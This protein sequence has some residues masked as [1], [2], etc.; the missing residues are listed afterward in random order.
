MNLEEARKRAEKLRKEIEHHNYLYYVL[1]QPEISDET[2]DGLMRELREV[3][4]R[5]PELVVP[6]SP[7]QRVG[8]EPLDEFEKV[9]HEVPML[10]LEN[11]FSEDELWSFF[12]R[13]KSVLSRD[14]LEYFCELKID[15][16]AV[17]LLYENGRL[18]RGATRGNGLVGEDVTNNIRTISSVPLK[19]VKPVEGILEVRGEVLMTKRAFSRL[20]SQREEQ[21]LPLFANPR[22]AAA[23]SLRQL[24]PKITAER[25]LNFFAYQVLYPERFGLRTQMEVIRW[26][27]ET[28]FPVQGTE[29][30]AF[31]EKEVL[32]YIA[33][34]NE[35]RHELAYAIDGVVVKVN[36]LA[37]WEVLG[38]T[39]KTPRWAVAY[40]YAPEEKRTRVKEIEISVG[41][42]GTLT[43]VAHLEP[44]RLS[45]TEVKRA[46]L[47]NADE[48]KRKDVRVGDTVW[49]RKA[50]EI[51]PEV[52]RVDITTRP[53]GLKPFEMPDS[54]PVCGS[55]V[56][57]L[58]EEVAV[59]CPNRTC[60]A[61]LRE[62][63]IHFASRSGMDI[64]GLG[65][66]IVDKLVSTGM[67]KDYADLYRLKIEDL[68]NLELVGEG[69]TRRLGE[70]TAKTIL[71]SI[72]ESK[73]RPLS[74]LLTAL[75]IR[76]VGSSVAELLA[77]TFGSI[78]E[79]MKS[80]E[81]KLAEIEGIGP[82]IAASVAAFF[83]DEQNRAMIEKLRSAGLC[84]TKEETP[85]NEE[86]PFSGLS[87]VFTGELESMTRSE[88][89]RLVKLLG[90][91][92]S[93]RVTGKTNLVVVGANPGSKL[94]EALKRNIH[95]ADEAEFVAMLKDAGAEP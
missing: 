60:P 13:T 44:V 11:A 70:K 93:S 87:V 72:E 82:R 40:K 41:R 61:Q 59:R 15:G 21:G 95:V 76:F 6:E 16:L 35:K 42:T 57:R 73:K 58:P 25:N 4:E 91:A 84:F 47:H 94:E 45:G 48:I 68:A 34:W 32:E 1:D 89:E 49:V 65:E 28:G 31:L 77:E 92:T 64:R 71:R 86:G 54:C 62:G 29:K 74:N 7:T 75:G 12:K 50:G 26:L 10:S 56:V 83:R 27:K 38:R 8:G 63:L 9:R 69:M 22:N 79:L 88:A 78:D 46:S 81:S 39:A 2:Y 33:F 55:K 85:R 30:P 18:V 36:E 37:L 90:G 67:V 80:D 14:K 19:T 3:E 5:F 17:S 52:L 53:E 20:N 43:P 24:N 23:G 51:I 66:R